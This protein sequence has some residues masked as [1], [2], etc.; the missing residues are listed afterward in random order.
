MAQYLAKREARHRDIID[1]YYSMLNEAEKYRQK[2]NS[3]AIVIQKFWRMFKV[4]WK[5]QDKIRASLTIQ[6]ILR[7]Y[8]G[9]CEFMNKKQKED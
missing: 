9:R 3:A 7:G 6:R 5:F 8:N 4:K 1:T 2:E